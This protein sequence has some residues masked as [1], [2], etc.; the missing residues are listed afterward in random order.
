MEELNNHIW[1]VESL[2]LTSFLKND[3][4][5]SLL[6]N[7]IREISGNEPLSINKSINYFQGLAPV[8]STMLKLE[9]NFNRI[10]LFLNSNAPQ[11][12][13]N[14]GI[15]TDIGSIMDDTI[16]RF[17]DVKGC[18]ISKRLA[19]GIIL[20]IPIKNS[21]EG[22]DVLQP[23]LKSVTN[24]KGTT[25]FLY[26]TNK[27]VQSKTNNELKL[28]RLMTWSIGYLQYLRIPLIIGQNNFI[29]QNVQQDL[30]PEMIC[31]L[32]M[33]FNTV[34]NEE[35][36]MSAVQQKAIITELITEAMKV[37]EKGEFGIEL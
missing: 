36:V 16:L 29:Q 12:E 37:A 23:I 8:N 9:W 34:E 15:Y 11:I 20:N 33:D 3:F 5:G 32:E 19:I 22:A 35:I 17:F 7:W 31:R 18:P 6:E 27:P 4:N 10:D 21:D 2:R 14:I 13:T 28:N 25:D 26:R 1:K 24:I 30:K